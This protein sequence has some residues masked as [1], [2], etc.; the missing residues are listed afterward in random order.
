VIQSR[1]S[2]AI[3]A[4]LLLKT[5]VVEAYRIPTGSMENTLL[6]GDFLLVNK[7]IYGAKSPNIF[8]CSGPFRISSLPAIEYPHRGDVIVFEWP[9]DRDEVKPPEPV[10]YIKRCIG[11]P[12]DTIQVIDRVVY[13]NGKIQP[14]PAGVKF[15]TYTVMPKGYPNPQ[16]FRR[17]PTSTKTT[18]VRLSYRR[19]ERSFTSAKAIS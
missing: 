2:F 16:I 13:V 15:D 1:V 14:F 7:F 18:M 10:N 3:I 17:E 9:G 6:V 19:K 12:G 4:A 5:F 11:L 8:H